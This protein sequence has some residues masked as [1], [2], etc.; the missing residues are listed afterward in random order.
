MKIKCL[1]SPIL[2]FL[3]EQ[4]GLKAVIKNVSLR[5]KETKIK[6]TLKIYMR[7]LVE[8]MILF[9]QREQKNY[10][11]INKELSCF[12]KMGFKR[13]SENGKNLPRNLELTPLLKSLKITNIL[14]IPK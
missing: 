11:R 9:Q 1:K 2:A 7:T 14:T 6:V 4:R 10:F 13:I 12:E 8:M 5:S 3:A